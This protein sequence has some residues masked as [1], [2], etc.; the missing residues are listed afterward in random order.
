MRSIYNFIC[1][2]VPCI[3]LLLDKD[4]NI[5]EVNERIKDFDYKIEDIIRKNL[6]EISFFISEDSINKL[7]ENKGKLVKFEVISGKKD[8]KTVIGKL[9]ELDEEK[10]KYLI[11]MHDIT[12]EEIIQEFYSLF[13][14]SVAGI[15][16]FDDNLDFL[17]VNPSFCNIVGYSKEELIGKKKSYEIVHPDD[18]N[19]A[20]EMIKKRFSGE[21]EVASYF[22]RFKR[23]D[24]KV[25]YCYAT[26]KCGKYK[27]KKVIMGSLI[28]ITDRVDIENKLKEEHNLL[29]Q[30]LNGVIYAITKIVEIKD[31][32]TAGHQ[33]NVAKL[34]EE[35]A[36]ELGFK[37][38]KIKE[39]SWASLLHDIGKI[40]VPAELLVLPRKLNPVEFSI[41]KT[42][43]LVAYNIL[44]VI[45]N[46]ENISEIVLQ[47][48]E[49]LDG[50]GYPKE[51]KGDQ[52][53]K[54]A[55]IIA[56]SDV[57][58]AMINHRPYRPALTLDDAF[59]EIYKN[60]GIKYDEEV[61]DICIY[62]FRKKNFKFT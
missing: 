38:D 47:H 15:Y 10:E 23:P 7:F 24:G 5:I 34:S 51:I 25:R 36:K 33:I 40:S 44:K 6:N 28:D 12:E 59:E 18:V 8:K 31:P 27:G 19:L 2:N 14:K 35:I 42:H 3:I 61:V 30:T 16:I 45:P 21:I 26:G 17:Y 53:L 49:R 9:I 32:Y 55:R 62:L 22:L 56:V 11:I 43:P 58:E 41:I 29:E 4:R 46:F 1:D 54:E 50:S 39:I 57:V 52:I 48:H 60:K 13:E 20:N 37:E